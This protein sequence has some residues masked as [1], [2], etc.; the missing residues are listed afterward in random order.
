MLRLIVALG[1]TEA[2]I[3]RYAIRR[4]DRRNDPTDRVSQ[5]GTADDDVSKAL[6]GQLHAASLVVGPSPDRCQ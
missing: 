5:L 1:L 2:S 4:H 6:N 3:S